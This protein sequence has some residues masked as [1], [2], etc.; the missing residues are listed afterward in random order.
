MDFFHL[1]IVSIFI[2]KKSSLDHWSR[3]TNIF[4]LF[5]MKTLHWLTLCYWQV[6]GKLVSLSGDS[7]RS[8]SR[9]IHDHLWRRTLH[10]IPTNCSSFVAISPMYL[11][12]QNAFPSCSFQMLLVAGSSGTQVFITRFFYPRVF[13]FFAAKYAKLKKGQWKER[14]IL[15]QFMFSW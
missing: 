13:Q 9:I 10:F 11:L 15:L 7:L 4:L 14:N 2:V 1:K 12:C 8:L 3:W 5:K 6:L